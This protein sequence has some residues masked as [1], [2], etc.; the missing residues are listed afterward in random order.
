MS[1]AAFISDAVGEIRDSYIAEA[2]LLLHRRQ[3]PFLRT[4]AAACIT[5]LLLVLPVG[6]ELKNGYVSNLLAPL[7]GGAQTK[8]VDSIGVPLNASTTVGDYTLTADAVIGDKYN[9]AIVYSLTH[10]EG[11][12]LPENLRFEGWEQSGIRRN[13]G[14]LSHK[15]G[16]DRKTLYLTE[17]FTGNQRLFFGK[18][19][20][21]VTFRDLQLWN[22]GEE[23]TPVQEGTWEL[24][25]TIR[26][27]DTMKTVWRGKEK[28]IGQQGD[29]F[30]V[31]K[32]ELSP[33]GLHLKLEGPS[34]FYDDLYEPNQKF[35]IC[36]LLGDGTR[37]P[38]EY[39]MGG[40]GKSDAQYWKMTCRA[41]FDTPV[42]RE[43]ICAILICGTEFPIH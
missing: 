23:D 5:L 31:Q 29:I 10:V 3:R 8:I 21:C 18:G 37:I 41:M 1:D 27:E 33:L 39:G 7:Y 42:P 4:L 32:I 13:S 36:L 26:Y 34:T 15:L 25:F 38:V 40:G 17:Q 43:S 22:R 11:Q 28:V 35:D 16:E 24:H 12:E 19:D 14:V 6:A 9:L 30:T 2:E 20:Y